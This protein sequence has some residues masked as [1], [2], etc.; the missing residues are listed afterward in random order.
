MKQN[1]ILAFLWSVIKPYKTWYLLMMQA[2]I[3]SAFY[4]VANM[5]ALKLVIDAF[6]A[7]N[8]PEYHD[9]LF[10]ILLYCGSILTLELVWRVSQFAWLKSQPFVRADIVSKSYDYVQNHSYSFF[11]NTLSGGVASKIKGIV[12]GYDNLWFGLHHRV[13]CPLLQVVVGVAALAFINLQ[14]FLLVLI[15]CAIFCPIM[16]K[17]SF[18][19]GRLAVATNDAKHEAIGLIADNLSNIFSIFFFTARTRELN[20]IKKFTAFDVASKDCA[21]IKC[22]LK[23]ALTGSVMYPLMLFSL[24]FLMIH[25]CRKG[26]VSAG[27]FMFVMTTAFFVIDALWKLVCEIGDFTSKM[28]DFRSSFSILKMPQELLDE[29]EVRELKL[30]GGEI[31][32]QNLSFRYKDGAVIF[33]NL[34]L[35]IKAGEKV[36]LVGISGAGKSTLI[37]LLLK[38]FKAS[39]GDILID[40]QSV[41][42]VSSDSLRAQIALI[43]QDTML[44]HRSIGENIGYAKENATQQEIEKAAKMANLHEFISSLANGYNTLVGERGIKLSGGQRQRVA[45]A[46]AMLK[47]API[48]ILDEATSSLDSH[49]ERQIQEGLNLLIENK[50]KTVIAIAH[51]LSTLKHLDRIIV[52]EKGK[53]IEEGRHDELLGRAGSMYKKLWE[54][55]AI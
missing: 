51:R 8:I 52:L 11:Q 12:N 44:F 28:G 21:Q 23:M 27:D 40:G 53:I 43:P 6:T 39:N 9:L 25:L 13:T 49:S 34:N 5:Y 48:L 24:L 31:I 1:T 32:F 33:D 41:Y 29:P 42:G 15:F 16:L 30:S 38:N 45:I 22:D 46:R 37:S 54:L 7:A 55:Q 47:D 20:R 17:M 19:I 3:I 36:G 26:A 10:P 4:G 14:V 35:R 2:P 18:Q 50:S